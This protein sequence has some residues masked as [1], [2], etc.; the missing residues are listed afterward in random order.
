MPAA[1]K[2]YVYDS[3]F[4]ERRAGSVAWQEPSSENSPQ[5]GAGVGS[6]Y[7]G[8]RGQ[9]H[10][11]AS[12]A[13]GALAKSPIRCYGTAL[14]FVTA[15]LV[16]TL[17]L[18]RFF[19]YP[20]LFLFFAAVMMSAWFGGMAPG[21]FAV[22]LS[23]VAV[24][25]YF[26]PPFYSLAVNATGG[27]Y[28]VSFIISTVVAS[29]VSSAQKKNEEALRSARDQLEA[30]V[31]ERTAEIRRANAESRESELQL[32]LLTEV[33]PQQI[34]SA[35]PD[36]SVDYCNR[37]LLDYVGRELEG[38]RG[39]RLIDAIHPDDRSSFRQ[40]W[41]EALSSGDPF[42]AE[43]RVCGADGRFRAFFTRGVPLRDTQGKTIRWYGTSTDIETRKQAEQA[44]M[45]MHAELAHLSRVLT[46]GELT[47]SIAHEV[48]QPLA[49]VVAYGQACLEWLAADPPNLEE[50][51][52]A[53]ERII[54]DGTR[55][56]TVLAHIRALFM[57]DTPVRGEVDLN[58]VIRELIVLVRDEAMRHHI[59]IRTELAA[60]LPTVTGVWV[61]LQQ[62]V[63]NLIMNGLDAMRETPHS[64]RELCI[65]SR[66][67][68]SN[69][70]LVRVED[71]GVGLGPDTAERVFEPFFTT[72]PE[73]IG[74]G[75]PISRSIIES[76]QGRLWAV[77]RAS[78]GAIFQ[79]TLPIVSQDRDG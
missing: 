27:M 46:M 78:G 73:G 74:M 14:F 56:G 1:M 67:S 72:K 43:W 71:C 52:Q 2:A 60:D 8:Q 30:R 41:Q 38:M 59:S 3:G 35:T 13:A 61:Q 17:L 25:Y 36:G 51:R 10:P 58:A 75:L 37:R 39:E 42:E 47:S 53:V 55:A 77:P 34:W 63:L 20:F 11:P 54:K 4:E 68:G 45:R 33:I 50:A 65:S 15:A 16:S 18:Q 76:H 40:T 12:G 48:N 70:V 6:V 57:K 9:T 29:W 22:V 23:T 32:R 7:H 26:T 19:P 62:V 66:S 79:F 28:F 31:A 21:L 49:A 5:A 69:H 24:D 44:L 64:F